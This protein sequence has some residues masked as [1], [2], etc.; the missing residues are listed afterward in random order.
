MAGR[1]E[2]AGEL[3]AGAAGYGGR[4]HRGI[5]Y[6]KRCT[7]KVKGEAAQLRAGCAWEAITGKYSIV[8]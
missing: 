3:G 2:R 6:H 5:L 4:G 7:S 1:G 8:V